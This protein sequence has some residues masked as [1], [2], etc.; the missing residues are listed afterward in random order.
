MRRVLIALPIAVTALLASASAVFA[1]LPYT[2]DDTGFGLERGVAW[3]FQGRVV[4]EVPG[5]TGL[6]ATVV[7]AVDRTLVGE[8]S[9]LEL[10]VR[11][12]DGC[13][14][15]W[16]GTGD[17]V[18]VAV[19]RYPGFIADP[20]PSDRLRPPYD[21]A[22]N[23][24]VAVWVLDGQRVVPGEGPHSWPAVS[25]LRPKTVDEVVGTLR[26]LPDTSTA[27]VPARDAVASW[28]VPALAGALSCA[29][30]LWTHSRR[31]QS[32]RTAP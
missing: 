19:P 20:T 6:P 15:F 8:G 2:F 5:A 31:G 24:L 27:S 1:C 4:H 7:I 17:S 16:Y 3:A 25:G 30:T 23:Y 14:G 12:D 32:R 9:G 29:V 10:S 11:Q 21:G 26:G 18:I 28:L 22:T 13:D